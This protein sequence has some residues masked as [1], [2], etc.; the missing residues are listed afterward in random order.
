MGWIPFDSCPQSENLT[1]LNQ[2]VTPLNIDRDLS[3][4]FD[5][6]GQFVYADNSTPIENYDLSAYLV[7]LSNTQAEL[8]QGNVCGGHVQQIKKVI[9]HSVA[10]LQFHW[11]QESIHCCLNMAHLN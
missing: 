6:S 8:T 4:T 3:D 10:I 7:P 5:F 1:L 2:S 11:T 9:S